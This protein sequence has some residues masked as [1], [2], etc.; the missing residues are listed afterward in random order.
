[1]DDIR[2]LDKKGIDDSNFDTV[3]DQ[4]FVTTLSDGTQIELLPKGEK[5]KVT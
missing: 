5:K 3:I 1:M 2:N 4:Q